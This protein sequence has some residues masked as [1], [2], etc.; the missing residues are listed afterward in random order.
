MLDR[1]SEEGKA[2]SVQ[3][4]HFN[5]SDIQIAKFK[6]LKNTVILGY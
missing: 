4:V 3:F 1:T 2:S 6:D 5:F